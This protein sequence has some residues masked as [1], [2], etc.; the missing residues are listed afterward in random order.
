MIIFEKG[1]LIIESV[2]NSIKQI[3]FKI[4][5]SFKYLY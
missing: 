4:D 3:V 1:L 5:Q 2:L